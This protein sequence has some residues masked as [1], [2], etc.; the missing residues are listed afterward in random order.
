MNS[1]ASVPGS[2][3]GRKCLNTGTARVICKIRAHRGND[4]RVA[5]YP[6]VRWRSP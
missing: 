5:N 2:A 3:G 1:L 6:V 4:A